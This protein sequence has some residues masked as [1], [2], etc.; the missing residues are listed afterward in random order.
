[1]LIAKNLAREGVARQS[2]QFA[3]FPWA[4]AAR[5]IDGNR[6]QDFQRS[7]CTHTGPDR[8]PWW[9]LDLKQ[10]RTV[11]A[12]VVYNRN[13]CCQPRLE[14]ADI[15]VGN[16]PDNNNPSCGSF[17]PLGVYYNLRFC[18]DGLVGRYVSVVIPNRKDFL[19]LC[20]VEVYGP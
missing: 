12:V 10:P 18:C 15:R 4:T 9:R 7:S 1:M 17:S 6:K 3:L 19:T 16:S 11:G 2:S 5:A 14:G 8:A 13:D 20:E